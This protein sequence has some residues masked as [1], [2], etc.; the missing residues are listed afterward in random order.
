MCVC[1]C[2]CVCVNC[3]ICKPFMCPW[4]RK[5]RGFCDCRVKLPPAPGLL[6][7]LSSASSWAF[8]ICPPIHSSTS[9]VRV[10]L[11]VMEPVE[12][13]VSQSCQAEPEEQLPLLQGDSPW[14]S[15]VERGSP[16]LGLLCSRRETRPRCALSLYISPPSPSMLFAL[17]NVLRKEPMTWEE[18][19]NTG[20]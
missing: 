3:M 8:V 20:N 4:S 6:E 2:V 5:R 15:T 13:S 11:C 1:V 16:C 14:C 9:G 18:W 19:V 10:P 12:K 7:A 17:L